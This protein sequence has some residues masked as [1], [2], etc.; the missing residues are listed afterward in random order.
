LELPL[1][2][3]SQRSTALSVLVAT[4]TRLDN[5]LDTLPW[6]AP[7]LLFADDAVQSGLT[8]PSAGPLDALV[9]DYQAIRYH[10]DI[11]QN[12]VM[13]ATATNDLC[14]NLGEYRFALSS[15]DGALCCELETALRLVPARD[16]GNARPA[17]FRRE[18][19][20]DTTCGD[21]IALTQ[22][23]V[24]AYLAL[25]GD[26]N[27]IH[28][29]PSAALAM[30]LEAPVVPGLMLASLIQPLCMRTAPDIRLQ[31]LKARFLAPLCVGQSFRVCV[32]R[33]KVDA[34]TNATRL[35]AYVLA[36][37]DRAVAIADLAMA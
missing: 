17:Q 31:Q 23:Q 19:L 12:A 4:E 14:E 16:V 37:G 21:P 25:S 35:R 10:R 24:N 18:A 15:A 36:N 34:R 32:Q 20:K 11:P 7:A 26:G 33:R 27:P 13:I 3:S 30:G 1:G 2:L 28:F 6:L 8:M 22:P 9:Q 29:D 5:A